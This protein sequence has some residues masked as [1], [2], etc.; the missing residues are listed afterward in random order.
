MNHCFRTIVPLFSHPFFKRTKRY[1]TQT[2]RYGVETCLFSCSLVYL[3]QVWASGGMGVS[4]KPPQ[5]SPRE[6]KRRMTR[7]TD[8][9]F[10]TWCQRNNIEPETATYI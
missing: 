2:K 10:Y 5:E 1:P 8:E 6:G 3:P 4:S 7:L 9:E